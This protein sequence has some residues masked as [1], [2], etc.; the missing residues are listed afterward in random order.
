MS[1]RRRS[2]AL[3]ALVFVA[4]ACKPFDFDGSGSA[5]LAYVTAEGDWYRIG[6]T[7]PFF[8]RP[9][10]VL[11]PDGVILAPGDYDG[12][13]VWEP[14][15]V[16]EDGVWRTGG[17]RGD[18]TFSAGATP[19]DIGGERIPVPAD[20]D[21]DGDTD[22]AWY[23]TID[24]TWHIEGVSPEASFG[25][26]RTDA[27]GLYDIPVPADYDGDGDA[28]LATYD[29]VTGDFEVL[30][31]GVVASGTSGIPVVA[32]YDADGDD[33]PAVADL[34][35]GEWHVEGRAA[36]TLPTHH[37]L[38]VAPADYTGGPEVERAFVDVE[39]GVDEYVV[40][41][42]ISGDDGNDSWA[43]S[44]PTALPPWVVYDLIRLQYI[45]ECIADGGTLSP[46]PGEVWSVD[47]DLPPDPE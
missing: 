46:I 25:T 34:G 20:Y 22:P 47:C 38:L 15:V 10:S 6:E 44:T 5:D 24:A 1:F 36:L 29:P 18:I 26:S 42:A 8:S 23:S 7:E 19:F 9:G 27:P 41:G 13:G 2:L 32:D 37:D 21:G 35:A 17:D 12:D 31:I 14:A 30:G 39:A 40:E 4:L 43:W 28:E 11:G 16:G 33:D 3:G 45:S